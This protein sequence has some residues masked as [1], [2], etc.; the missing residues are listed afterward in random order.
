[1]E[2]CVY[3]PNLHLHYS[4]GMHPWAFF[5]SFPLFFPYAPTECRPTPSVPFASRLPAH[6]GLDVNAT[7]RLEWIRHER[8]LKTATLAGS[9]QNP[10]AWVV[11]LAYLVPASSSGY[12]YLASY[13]LGILAPL[14]A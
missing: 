3:C 1:M 9:L 6:I 10:N 2:R 14:C 13:F 7:A 4:P 12:C 8:A 5:D 11:M